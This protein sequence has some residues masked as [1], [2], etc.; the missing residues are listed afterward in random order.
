MK[1]QE[2]MHEDDPEKLQKAVDSAVNGLLYLQQYSKMDSNS[3]LCNLGLIGNPI[4]DPSSP[5]VTLNQL[6]AMGG[7]GEEMKQIAPPTPYQALELSDQYAAAI[8]S[9]SSTGGPVAIES[10][11]RETTLR[12]TGTENTTT[13]GSELQ[14]AAASVLAAV[15]RNPKKR[16]RGGRSKRGPSSEG[17]KL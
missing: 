1:M 8:D 5:Q 13:Q 16:K 9:G 12:G 6:L 2:N 7:G 11:A 3:P 14:S 10:D 17:S 4:Q 15:R